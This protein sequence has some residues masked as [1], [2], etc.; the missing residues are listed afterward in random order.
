VYKDR[1]FFVPNGAN[2]D[3]ALGTGF[4]SDKIVGSRFL[5]DEEQKLGVP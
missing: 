1:L 5:G 3:G 2:G 4:Y